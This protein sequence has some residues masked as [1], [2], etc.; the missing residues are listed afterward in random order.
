[1]VCVRL[2]FSPTSGYVV[3]AFSSAP[4]CLLDCFHIITSSHQS[5]SP[6]IVQRLTESRSCITVAHNWKSEDGAEKHEGCSSFD[7]SSICYSSSSAPS[8]LMMHSLKHQLIIKRH[9]YFWFFS[10]WPVA[11]MNWFHATVILYFLPVLRGANVDKYSCGAQQAAVIIFYSWISDTHT[12]PA[13]NRSA[14]LRP[15]TA[16]GHFMFIGA[17]PLKQW[18]LFCRSTGSVSLLVGVSVRSQLKFNL[19]V[20]C[21]F[22]LNFCG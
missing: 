12:Q 18:G 11:V 8:T 6:I 16:G 3:P 2:A 13:V 9:S 15:L 21:L 5:Q 14:A 7:F 1:M 22:L 20:G 19:A 10:Y 17:S 4:G